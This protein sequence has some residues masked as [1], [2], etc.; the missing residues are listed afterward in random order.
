MDLDLKE[1]V[2]VVLAASSG[3][4]KGIA[5]VLAHEG[6]NLA[7]CARDARRLEVTANEIRGVGA[8][9]LAVVTDVASASSLDAFYDQVIDGYGKIDILINN[10]GGPPAGKSLELSEDDY[11]VAY[12]LTLMSVVRSCRRVVPLM[13]KQRWGR[14]I[15]IES[16][17][18]KCALD[19]MVLSNVFRSAVAAFAKTLSTEYARDG[20]RVHTLMSGPFNTN[21]MQELGT[22][23]ARL[24]DISFE[25]WKTEA[26][27][28]TSVGRFGDPLE[29]GALTA[30]LASD[31]AEYMNGT[32]IAID[33]GAL[34]TIS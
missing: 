17:S 13:Q 8:Q 12:Q 21:R 6:C 3:I 7:I 31:K 29:F 15:N 11:A 14:I 26:E 23:A 19:N 32:C 28:G 4:G 25:Q 10:A 20:I 22:T 33:G 16:T 1:R 9:V 34:K 5:T 30:F 24:K 27:E 2:A 18:I